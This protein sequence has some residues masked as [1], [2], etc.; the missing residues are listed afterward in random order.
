MKTVFAKYRNLIPFVVITALFLGLW[1]YFFKGLIYDDAYI[2]FRFS[3]HWAAGQG[4]VWN[5]GENPVE[6][7]SSFAWVL[8]GTFFQLLGILPHVIM[9][10]VGVAAWFIAMAVLLPKMVDAVSANS[11][12]SAGS[13]QKVVK[14]LIFFVLVANSAIGFQAFHGLETALFSLAILLVVYQAILSQTVRDYLK[15][16]VFSLLLIMVR[17]DGA[18]IVVPVW[19]LAFLLSPGSRKNIF[20][21]ALVSAG[22]IG[23]YTAAKWAYF[24]YPVPNTF[25]IKEAADSLAGQNYVQDYLTLMAP[26]LVFLVYACGRLGLARALTDKTFVILIA[27]AVLFTIAYLGINPILGNV[28]RFLIPTLPLFVLAGLRA[29]SLAHR[30]NTCTWRKC[31]CVP[32]GENGAAEERPHK[33]PILP[34]ATEA[35]LFFAL[36]LIA[37]NVLFNIKVYRQ[38]AFLQN[39]FGAIDQTLVVRGLQLRT[40]DTLSPAPLLATGD[41]GAIPYFSDLPTLDVI[42]LADETIAH[43]GLTHEYIQARKPDLLILQDL[44]VTKNSLILA[45]G[46]QGYTNPLLNVDGKSMSLNMV[47]Y[48]K[49][50]DNPEAAHTGKGSTYQIVT[51]PGF[52][53]DY[54]FILFWNFGDNRYYVFV[55]RAYPQFDALVN[56]LKA[57]P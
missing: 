52:T 31:R 37:V 9:P 27:P 28:Y 25:Y 20:V 38:Y 26:L 43:G 42:G 48:S 22:L 54:E 14:I 5:T 47:F 6:G 4:L 33:Q 10:W 15:L 29:Y 30:P 53:A 41:I 34:F 19:V 8:I 36:A 32:L 46:P 51:T 24:G 16:A 3:N 55:R 12:D 56:I 45:C 50:L 13:V 39:Y 17:P 40:A 23:A 7:F 1:V 2:A 21:G 57:Q 49:V 35:F 18:A 11:A 44:D